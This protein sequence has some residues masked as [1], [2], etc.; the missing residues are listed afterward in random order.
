MIRA[1]NERKSTGLDR[2]YLDPFQPGADA[3]SRLTENPFPLFRPIL[4]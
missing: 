2:I 1:M 3:K 4:A